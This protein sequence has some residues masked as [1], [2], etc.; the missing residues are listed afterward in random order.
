MSE[1]PVKW[2]V[3]PEHP[4][5]HAVPMTDEEIAEHAAFQAEVTAAK[6]LR[7]EEWRIQDAVD[8]N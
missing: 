8:R 3:D 6:I 7:E 4:E 5:G 1:R 2:I